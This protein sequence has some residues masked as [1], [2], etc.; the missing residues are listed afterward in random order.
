MVQAR[1]NLL[2]KSLPANLIGGN[3]NRR[4]TA[5]INFKNPEMAAA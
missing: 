5:R 3:P 2:Q 1:H 4:A